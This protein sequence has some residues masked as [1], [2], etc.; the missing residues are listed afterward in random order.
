MA[1]SMTPSPCVGDVLGDERLGAGVHRAG[2]HEPGD[3]RTQ[4]VLGVVA[5]AVLRARGRPRSVM[6]KAVE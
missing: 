6:P 4:D 3:R 2:E 1:R 5:A